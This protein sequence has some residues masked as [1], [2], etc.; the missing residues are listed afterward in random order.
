MSKTFTVAGVSV[1]RGRMDVT[2]RF[3]NGKAA[4]RTKV[5]EKNGDHDIRLFD[6][7]VAMDKD[8][9]IDWVTKNHLGA[10]PVAAQKPAV[11]AK[12]AT[13]GKR[14]LKRQEKAAQAAA[15]KVRRKASD[16]A[17]AK[18]AAGVNKADIEFEIDESMIPD[19][20]RRDFRR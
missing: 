15:D 2:W 9:A 5:L 10:K 3:A 16:E 18:V 14:E 6:L 1:P 4:A 19:F 17:Y 12:A 8:A 20:I 11:A 13:P 7:P